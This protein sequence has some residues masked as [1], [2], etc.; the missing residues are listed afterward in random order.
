MPRGD[1]A[2]PRGCVHC[3][4]MCA[5]LER[6]HEAQP[7]MSAKRGSNA[8]LAAA[9]TE[10][11]GKDVADGLC[12]ALAVDGLGALTRLLPLYCG[13]HLLREPSLVHGVGARLKRKHALAA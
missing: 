1:E 8:R 2:R 5:A 10:S 3:R 13:F 11:Q 6:Q 12:A 4:E 7:S 9:E